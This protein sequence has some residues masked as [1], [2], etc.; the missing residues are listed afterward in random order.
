MNDQPQNRSDINS[1]LGLHQRAS[2]SAWVPTLH[3][4]S[5]MHA[6]LIARFERDTF[7]VSADPAA[8]L[9]LIDI[10]HVELVFDCDVEDDR[11]WSVHSTDGELLV[12]EFEVS[13]FERQAISHGERVVCNGIEMQFLFPSQ[14]VEIPAPSAPSDSRIVAAVQTLGSETSSRN[15]VRSQRSLAAAACLAGAMGVGLASWLHLNASAQAEAETHAP[16]SLAIAPIN[17]TKDQTASR[18]QI[19]DFINA[20]RFP[21][22]VHSIDAT[23]INLVWSGAD[24]LPARTQQLIGGE[25]FGRRVKWVQAST[26]VAEDEPHLSPSKRAQ[27]AAIDRGNQKTEETLRNLGLA[28]I[29]QVQASHA[30]G[31]AGRFILTRGGH[32]VFEGSDLRSGA[33]LKAIGAEE[34]TVSSNGTVMIVPY[35]VAKPVKKIASS[36]TSVSTGADITP[37]TS[38][39]NIKNTPEKCDLAQSDDRGTGVAICVSRM[40]RVSKKTNATHLAAAVNS[41]LSASENGSLLSINR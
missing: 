23:S 6:G 38:K 2:V 24:T 8:D 39:G 11:S 34:M 12:G 15:Q 30:R 1:D 28:D 10:A 37:Y 14:R 13:N 20:Q 33:Q 35:D 40:S 19:T 18:D 7:T 9:M 4:K 25:L 21:V 31:S 16:T 27:R 26:A 36:V 22:N 29:A 41:T 32:R 17:A 3:I 5:G